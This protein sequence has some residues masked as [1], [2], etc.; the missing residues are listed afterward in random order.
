MAKGLQQIVEGELDLWVIMPED[1]EKVHGIGPKTSRFFIMWI[2][3]GE[4]YA[5]L[6]VHILRWLKA[7]GHDAPRTTPSYPKYSH[8]EAIFIAEA[9]AL[10]KTPRQLDY[11]IWEVGAKSRNVA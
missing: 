5:A 11:E 10:G 1:L 8:L 2:R 6:D 3:P 9:D 7:R 4:R